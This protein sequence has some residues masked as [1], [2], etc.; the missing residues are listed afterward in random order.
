MLTR[1]LLLLECAIMLI[2][3]P[4]LG[5]PLGGPANITGIVKDVKTG[6]GLAGANVLVLGTGKGAATDLNGRFLIW[7]VPQGSYT[8]R[9][10]FVGY[11]SVEKPVELKADT[12]VEVQFRMEP[13]TIEGNEVVVTAQAAGQN[14]AINQ[15]LS[16]N[17]IVNVVSAAKIQ[18]L[19]D[20]NAAESVGR[21]PGVSVLRN[22]G[23]GTEVVIRGL[24]PKY[25][26]V[27]IDGIQVS[28]P[29]PSDRSTDLSG[30]SS[31]MLGGIK[32]YK[33]ITPDLDANVIGGI[34]DFQLREAREGE[35]GTPGF[36]LLGQGGYKQLPDAYNKFN[37]YKYIGSGEERFFDDALGVFAQVDIERE[38]LTSNELG[39]SYNHKGNSTTDYITTALNLYDT[40]R[41]I[42][43]RNGALVLDYRL[44]EGRI[45]L[46]NFF[47]SG[48]SDVQS[49]QETFDISGN[50]HFYTLSDQSGES[51]SAINGIEFENAFPFVQVDAKISS[52]Y[53]DSRNP[54]DWS[55]EFMQPSAGLTQFSNQANVNPQDIPRAANND[56]SNTILYLLSSNSS[57]SK[58]QAFTGSLDL[59]TDFTL[60]DFVNAEIKVGGAERYQTRQFV[61]DVYDGGGLQ[62]GGSG[63]VNNLI[64]NAFGLPPS[65]IYKI[66]IGYFV[67]PGYSYGSFLGGAYQMVSP[68]NYGMMAHMA[69]I[70][71]ANVQWIADNFGMQSYARDNLLSTTNNYS[72]FENQSALY[73]MTVLDVGSDVTVTGGV[74]YQNLRTNYEGP[75]GIESR[76]S[77]NAYNH[78]DTTVVQNHGYWLPDISLK[79]KPLPWADL[80]LSYSNT[81]AYP[82]YNA[83]I[84][85]IDVGTAAVSWNN[86][87]LVPTRSTNYDAHVSFYDNAIGLFT[88]G[89][90]W[91]KIT[92]LIYPWTFFVSGA[93]A[94]QYFPPSMVG[95]SIPNGTY[96]INSYVNDAGTINDYGIELDWETH[97][98]YLPG[99]FSGL[100]LGVNY[101]HI[102]SKAEYP[103]Q[104]VSSNGRTVN[105]I[106]T[107][108][109]DR[110]LYQPD[111]IFNL[112]LGYDYMAFSARV[113]LLYHDDI[114]TGPNFWPQLRT[115]TAGYRRWDLSVKQGL[116]WFG[117]ELYGDLYN[118][119]GAND[120][121]IIQKGGVPQSE[122][123]YGMTGDLGLRIKL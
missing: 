111:N 72:G 7:S 62:F 68:L 78:Y 47:G 24:A 64:I 87:Q 110:L 104:V 53:S 71:Q 48:L 59:K 86:Y 46:T 112:S 6:E 88:V 3:S 122:Q 119:N 66:P 33:T 42:E 100:V 65:V 14:A 114:F 13:V 84:P 96:Q 116:P 107:T 52:A 4:G 105:Y 120:I 5:N 10:T 79:Y 19:P 81:L 49:R 83:V 102:F 108:F 69:D 55:I 60:L 98:W 117:I 23:E 1:A 38:N 94:L 29:N 21:L 37:N 43:R 123:D 8:I 30:I 99:V 31:N 45:K 57:F 85:R 115:Y 28:S 34:V 51:R 12:S 27:T 50:N 35:S 82:D 41:D 91:K 61:Q 63:P 20:Q 15:Q 101:S 73:A 54:H 9:A 121:S 18:E 95:T 40:P 25:N 92:N 11:K 89:G 67:D 109:T 70:L 2:A 17:Q 97:F 77:F 118:I 39:A 113:S 16:S 44:P 58:T 103:F 74:R 93:S 80:R 32:I 75:R 26:Q 56:F 106:D 76:N 22:G 36:N 90:F